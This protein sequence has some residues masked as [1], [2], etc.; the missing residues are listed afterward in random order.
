MLSGNGSI[1]SIICIVLRNQVCLGAINDIFNHCNALFLTSKMI[2]FEACCRGII[3]AAQRM[4]STAFI[5]CNTIRCVT[6]V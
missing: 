5:V 3:E 4:E 1:F 6:S 2:L